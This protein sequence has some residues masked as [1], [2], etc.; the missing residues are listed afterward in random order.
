LSIEI[1]LSIPIVVDNGDC[2]SDDRDLRHEW[3]S[4]ESNV[5]VLWVKLTPD[6][7]AAS[8]KWKP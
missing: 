4:F 7:L 3:S 2:G 5:G 6:A 8:W 1:R